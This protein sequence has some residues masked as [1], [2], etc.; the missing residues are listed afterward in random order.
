MATNHRRIRKV[1]Y[2]LKKKWG[3]PVTLTKES[4]A[5]DY[6]TGA[7]T[8]TPDD[9]VIVKRAI[10]LPRKIT[11]DFSYDL[12][13]IAANKNF[14]YGGFY[15]V[16]DR[17]IIIDKSDVGSSFDFETDDVLFIQSKGY[18]IKSIEK[19]DEGGNV[20]AYLI[21]ATELEANS[22]I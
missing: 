20:L 5:Y 22:G 6:V 18:V 13:F 12:S 8:L 21:V 9:S 16:S 19:Y 17:K 7:P 2:S 11:P 15:T 4:V 14:T 1:L 10:I 3:T